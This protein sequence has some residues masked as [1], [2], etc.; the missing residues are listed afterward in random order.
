MNICSVANNRIMTNRGLKKK[1]KTFNYLLEENLQ[2]GG[3]KNTIGTKLHHKHPSFLLSFSSIKQ[4]GFLS[5]WFSPHWS[6]AAA[7]PR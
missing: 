2:V 4:V 3:S 6:K 5:L 7:A 1:T